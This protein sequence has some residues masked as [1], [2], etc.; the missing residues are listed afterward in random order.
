MTTSSVN[1]I[2]VQ[3]DIHDV[4]LDGSHVFVG[5][6]GFFGGPLESIFHGVFDFTHELDSLGGI[7]KNIGSLIFGSEGPDL[8]SVILVPTVFIL[9]MSGSFL[10]ISFRSTFSGFDFFSKSFLEGFGLAIESVMLVG[11][12]GEADLAGF[13]SD[14]FLICNDGVG[15]DEF[16]IGEFSFQIVETNFNVEFSTSGDN[17]FSG[18]FSADLH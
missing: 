3:N 5:H 9:K 11:G 6:D 13:F 4:N 16:N 15:L 7:T 18:F 12:F 17:V 2:S 10:G 14:S 1:G 8:K